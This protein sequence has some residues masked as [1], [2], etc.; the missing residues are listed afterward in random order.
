MTTN[1]VLIN[2]AGEFVAKGQDKLGLQLMQV[3]GDGSQIMT[4]YAHKLQSELAVQNADLMA[5]DPSTIKVGDPEII[6]AVRQGAR[7]YDVAKDQT[8]WVIKA[9]QYAAGKPE[10]WNSDGT[11]GWH[12]L[13]VAIDWA[14]AGFDAGKRPSHNQ[15]RSLIS[16]V[17]YHQL[18]DGKLPGK[19]ELARI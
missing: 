7:R 10:F 9:I 15:L 19:G 5:L 3:E 12:V 2:K 1:F 14:R 18:S 6:A 13:Q 17:L 8:A 16:I 4:E 11:T